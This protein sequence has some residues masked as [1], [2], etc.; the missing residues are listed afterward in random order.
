[1]G[2]GSNVMRLQACERTESQLV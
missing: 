2:F 1:M